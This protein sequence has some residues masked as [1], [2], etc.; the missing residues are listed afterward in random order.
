MEGMV[1]E[2]LLAQTPAGTASSSKYFKA[3]QT[4]YATDLTAQ[5]LGSLGGINTQ[6]ISMEN[7]DLARTAG[8]QLLFPLDRIFDHFVT[9]YTSLQVAEDLAKQCIQNNAVLDKEKERKVLL[10]HTFKKVR[11]IRK[12]IKDCA[13]DIDR[14]MVS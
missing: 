5:S 6:D 9:A 3:T 13:T 14:L 10:K 1:G 11:A 8:Q 7:E 4:R 2:A 12:M